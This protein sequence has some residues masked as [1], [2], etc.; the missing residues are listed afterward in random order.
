MFFNRK[1]SLEALLRCSLLLIS[2]ASGADYWPRSRSFRLRG[3]ERG[4]SWR[5]RDYANSLEPV[6]I[7]D[8]KPELYRAFKDY[9]FVEVSAM[10]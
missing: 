6:V 4:K 3:L 5:V 8:D 2:G 9:L 7:S 1:E 10:D